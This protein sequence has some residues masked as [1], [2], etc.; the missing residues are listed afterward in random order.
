MK[1][2]MNFLKKWGTLMIVQNKWNLK[3]YEVIKKNGIKVTLKR[4]DDSEFEISLNEFNAS[5]KEIRK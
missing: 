4:S 5:Y 2:S 3:L 1:S